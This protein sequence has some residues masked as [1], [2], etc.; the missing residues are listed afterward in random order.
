MYR[1]FLASLAV[2]AMTLTAC[3]GPADSGDT[4]GSAAEVET[5]QPPAPTSETTE[6]EAAA[7]TPEA[8]AEATAAA[9]GDCTGS[10]QVTIALPALGAP[11]LDIYSA[12]AEGFFADHGVEVALA[13]TPGPAA[14]I[15][16][17][18]SGTAQVGM[19]FA[20]QA[21]AA[22][23]VGAPVKIFAGLYNRLTGRL[24]AAPDYTG[25]EQLR[26][27]QVASSAPDDILTL[28]TRQRLTELGLDPSAYDMIIVP[29]SEQRYQSLQSGAVGAS[30]LVAPRDQQA[31]AEGYTEVFEIEQSGILVAHLGS[32][33]FL[34]QR[35]A[36]AVCYVRAIQQAQAW[37]TDT[38]NRERAVEILAEAT[39]VSP[40]VAATTYDSFIESGGWVTGA[41][42]VQEDLATTLQFMVEAGKIFDESPDQE[43]Y[44]NTEI[45]ELANQAQ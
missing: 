4:S 33:E 26:G 44:A 27:S 30:L 16:A 41:E 35:T 40:E 18:A 8:A 2:V 34:E 9:G 5:G 20:E 39:E 10:E 11:Y 28:L 31:L 36:A 1:L 23:E 12:M 24:I 6:A 3:G 7:E 25:I 37:M 21:L 32:D 38:A 45:V 17:V 42:I 22:I 13:M 14:T 29:S 43:K 15:A 19:P